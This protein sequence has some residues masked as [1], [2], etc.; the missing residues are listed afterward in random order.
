MADESHTDEDGAPRDPEDRD[1]VSLMKGYQDGRIECF[2]GIYAALG[3]QIVNYLTTLA[4]NRARAEDLAQEVFLQMHRSRHTYTPPR[5][6]KPWV[7]GI[8]RN[9]FR[10]DRRKRGRL[11]RHETT[12]EEDLPVFPVDAFAEHFSERGGLA[13]ALEQVRENRREAL[14]L[15]FVWGFSFREIGQL[16]GISRSAAKVRS[17]RGMKDLRELL[18]DESSPESDEATRGEATNE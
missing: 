1:L 8:A 4:R 12:V 7:F 17:H 5:P 10:M 3:H 6:V 18:A 11:A 15:H 2:E 13:R 14:L 9:V 16:L